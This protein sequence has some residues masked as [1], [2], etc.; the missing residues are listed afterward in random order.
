MLTGEF[1]QD[2]ANRG[3]ESVSARY[4]D[5]EQEDHCMQTELNNGSCPSRD[6]E[7]CCRDLCSVWKD[8]ELHAFA[9]QGFK[10]RGLSNAL[11]GTEMED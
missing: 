5:L 3:L 4:Q 9:A 1:V 6:R 8:E 7:D 2:S 11:D 10:R